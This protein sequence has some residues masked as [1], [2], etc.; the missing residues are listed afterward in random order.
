[1]TQIIAVKCPSEAALFPLL[2]IGDTGVKGMAEVEAE[3]EAG[4][5]SSSTLVPSVIKK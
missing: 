5:S 1:L 4:S 3:V 2:L